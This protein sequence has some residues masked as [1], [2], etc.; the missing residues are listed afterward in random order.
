[1]DWKT[2]KPLEELKLLYLMILMCLTV[3][4]YLTML[5]YLMILW[6]LPMMPD[7]V[8]LPDD[9]DVHDYF[10]LYLV[11]LLYLA[12]CSC[13]HLLRLLHQTPADSQGDSL[14]SPPFSSPALDR[15]IET[16]KAEES[17]F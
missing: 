14:D 2:Q 15:Y 6:Y 8:D 7:D 13:V 9:A 5:M 12:A 11:V 16:Q 4:L 3:L 10:F 1:M 17:T